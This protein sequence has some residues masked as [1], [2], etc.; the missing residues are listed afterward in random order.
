M[1]KLVPTFS[2]PVDM[3]SNL[4]NIRALPANSAV[5]VGIFDLL[6]TRASDVF[7]SF[8]LD[9]SATGMGQI[10]LYMIPSL[11]GV[12]S[13]IQAYTLSQIGANGRFV[14]DT[15]NMPNL[16]ELAMIPCN[17][18]YSEVWAGSIANLY[19]NLP[20]YFCLALA[21]Y[22]TVA[23]GSGTMSIKARYA[24]FEYV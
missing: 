5:G 15:A 6:T 18:S 11:D 21:N 20:P 16:V 24:S 8:D 22:S 17:V 13:G 2:A 19:G 4:A 23:W 12:T 9:A 3:V 10:G 1:P 14:P 7:V